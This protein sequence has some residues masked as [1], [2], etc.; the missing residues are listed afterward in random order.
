M[1]FKVWCSSFV[2]RTACTYSFVLF[3]RGFSHWMNCISCDLFVAIS[4][5]ILNIHFHDDFCNKSAVCVGLCAYT[6][7]P[8]NVQNYLLID[9]VSHPSRLWVLIT[10][11]YE[12]Q[13]SDWHIFSSAVLY[14]CHLWPFELTH[15]DNMQI[16][17]PRCHLWFASHRLCVLALNYWFISM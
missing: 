4:I 17:M 6:I 7:I 9:T 1:Y 5:E 13:I 8:W 12:S 10:P 2:L 15:S 11:H 3:C 16:L 14:W